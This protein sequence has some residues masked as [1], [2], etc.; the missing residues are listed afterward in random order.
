MNGQL[1]I[2]QATA[3]DSGRYICGATNSA[4]TT[5]AYVDVTIR[6][7]PT[8]VQEPR[9]TPAYFSGESGSSFTL[10]CETNEDYTSIRWEKQDGYL[11]FDHRSSN[12]ILTVRNAR[13]EDSGS[14]VCIVTVASGQT[15]RKTA[16][17]TISS[18]PG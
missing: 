5:F 1:R 3:A 4:G 8:G 9:V 7:V 12:G 6:N 16:T 13:P 14:Y 15:G 2:V 10:T 18:S 17:V 11:P